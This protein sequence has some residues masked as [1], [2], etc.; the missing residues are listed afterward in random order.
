[1]GLE[2]SF[3]AEALKMN[4][5]TPLFH[6]VRMVE[7]CQQQLNKSSKAALSEGQRLIAK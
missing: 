2:G 4:R 3:F 1:M 5:I 7:L 6:E